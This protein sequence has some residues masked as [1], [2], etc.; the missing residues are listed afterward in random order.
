MLLW[1][2]IE[3]TGLDQHTR[4]LLSVG[5]IATD[6]SLRELGRV[7]YYIK[8][9]LAS[10]TWDDGVKEMH[11]KSGVLGKV[12]LSPYSHREVT[13]L[14]TAFIEQLGMQ[15]AYMSGNTISFDRRWLDLH[16]PEVTKLLHYRLLDVSTLKTLAGLWVPGQ[17]P[18]LGPKPHSPI[19]DLERSILELGTWK[20]LLFKDG[21]GPALPS[22]A[23]K[24]A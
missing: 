9:D 8:H 5:M 6:D 16:M 21:V 15:K 24:A 2:D 22:G 19:A 12:S 14:L 17:V 23:L 7:E 18:D 20:A 1:T 3:T 4:Q 13:G 11:E 10:L